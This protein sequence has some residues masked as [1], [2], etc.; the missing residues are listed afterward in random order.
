M[1]KTISKLTKYF[2]YSILVV[3]ISNFIFYVPI[4]YNINIDNFKEIIHLE[5]T[6]VIALIVFFALLLLCEKKKKDTY[7]F[8]TI[9]YIYFHLL[10]VISFVI[11]QFIEFYI[12]RDERFEY[13][14]WN[15]LFSHREEITQLFLSRFL[16]T[17]II[18]VY[19]V[20]SFF[21]LKK[22]TNHKI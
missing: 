19:I 11:Y 2:L 3:I 10:S 9:F 8:Y 7:K 13:H 12:G 4:F 16:D 6:D 15:E 14:F 1:N 18:S 5:R 22:Y 17:D 20:S 21:I